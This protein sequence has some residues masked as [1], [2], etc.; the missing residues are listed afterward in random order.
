MSIGKAKEAIMKSKLQDRIIIHHN[1]DLAEFIRQSNATG[2]KPHFDVVCL[3]HSIWYFESR[4]ALSKTLQLAH[5]SFLSTTRLCLAEWALQ[6][7]DVDAL[8][9]LLAA[10]TEGHLEQ[11]PSDTIPFRNIRTLLSPISVRQTAETAGW[12]SSYVETLSPCK[13]LADGRLESGV[14]VASKWWEEAEERCRQLSS[15]QPGLLSY[16]TQSWEALG[17]LPFH[18]CRHPLTVLRR[19]LG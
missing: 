16:L 7:D 2:D 10:L 18:V 4:D 13:D 5:G 8:P 3:S 6:I 9:H 1:T 12:A 14:V 17:K 19:C 11:Y 15:T